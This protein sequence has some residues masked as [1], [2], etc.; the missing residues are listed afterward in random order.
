MAPQMAPTPQ[1]APPAAPVP[2]LVAAAAS[3][4]PLPIGLLL[5]VLLLVIVA[6]LGVG[7]WM[8]WQSRQAGGEV[9]AQTAQGQPGTT[10]TSGTTGTQTSVETP[11]A[12]LGTAP[13][14]SNAPSAA[15]APAVMPPTPAPVTSAVSSTPPAN[16]PRQVSPPPTSPAPRTSPPANVPPAGQERPVPPRSQSPERAPVPVP[17][18]AP[19]PAAPEREAEPEPAAERVDRSMRTGMEVTF[20]VQPEDA[21]VLV[22]GRVIGEAQDWNGQRG[23]R[24]YVFSDAGSH[25]IKIRKPGLKEYRVAV[26]AGAVGGK[27]PI[28]ARLQSMVAEEVDASDLQT[29]RV[30]EAVAFRLQPPSPTAEV[31]VDGQP[32]GLARRFGGGGFLRAKEW[33]ELAPGKHRISIV[34]PGFRRKDILVEVVATAE[35]DR[36]RIDVAM[37][38]GGSGE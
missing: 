19:V 13:S 28:T 18:P 9:A 2:S 33:L 5:G 23:A 15:P 10:G 36:E 37:T 11:P 20:N 6:A 8:F 12:P 31:R 4:K 14:L 21:H 35:R 29:V 7:G 1:A 38:A 26:E 32:V 16:V 25:L 3:R 22:D 24:S 27:T 30:R 34:S 17:A